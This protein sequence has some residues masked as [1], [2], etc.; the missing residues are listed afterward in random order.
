MPRTEKALDLGFGPI[1]SPSLSV[2]TDSVG[3]K[4]E[5]LHRQHPDQKPGRT[6]FESHQG[7]FPWSGISGRKKKPATAIGRVMIASMM[8]N[9][10]HPARP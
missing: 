4:L 6:S 1:L 7:A 8:N 9:H 10:R 2:I 5:F 3:C